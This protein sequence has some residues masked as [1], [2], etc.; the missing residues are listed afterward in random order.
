[1]IQGLRKT[2]TGQCQIIRR[3]EIIKIRIEIETNRT[4][5]RTNE[6]KNGSLK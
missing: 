1:M 3:K 5:Q 6:T 2:I 4:A